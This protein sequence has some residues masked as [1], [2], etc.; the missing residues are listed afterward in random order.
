MKKISVMACAILSACLLQAG[1]AMAAPTASAPAD[2]EQPKA[3]AQTATQSEEQAA[4]KDGEWVES[5]V[6]QRRIDSVMK[7]E[8]LVEQRDEKL[9]IRE[10]NVQT[11]ETANPNNLFRKSR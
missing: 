7:R 11:E 5:S 2:R 8:R 4:D 1:S 6:S 10:R 3:E 9:K